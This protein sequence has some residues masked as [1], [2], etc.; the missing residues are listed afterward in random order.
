MQSSA[1]QVEV[2][3]TVHLPAKQL[4]YCTVAGGG[5]GVSATAVVVWLMSH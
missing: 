5:W 1:S 4:V 3:G 2:D